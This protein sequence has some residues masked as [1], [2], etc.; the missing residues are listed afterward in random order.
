MALLTRGKSLTI[1][2]RYGH[3]S[4]GSCWGKFYAGKTCAGGN[5]RWAEKWNGKLVID[6]AG[7]LVYGSSD[8]F[9]RKETREMLIEWRET[10]TVTAEPAPQKEVKDI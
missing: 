5:F 7:Y 1:S 8:G 10:A 9:S 6:E 2:T 4:R 3:L